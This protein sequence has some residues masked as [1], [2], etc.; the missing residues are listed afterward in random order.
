[1]DKLSDKYEKCKKVCKSETQG[2]KVLCVVHFIKRKRDMAYRWL[3]YKWTNK[4]LNTESVK[5]VCGK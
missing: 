5:K 2:K 4:V 3:F 1:M